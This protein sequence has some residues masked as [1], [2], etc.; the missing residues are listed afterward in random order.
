[1]FVFLLCFALFLVAF[2]IQYLLLLS[3]MH[4]RIIIHRGTGGSK[5][6]Q[7]MDYFVSFFVFVIFLITHLS[8]VLV[9][10]NQSA[11][12]SCLKRREGCVGLKCEAQAQLARLLVG[13][14]RVS[15]TGFRGGGRRGGDFVLL[16]ELLV[17]PGLFGKRHGCADV[18]IG[19]GARAPGG[20]GLEFL[21]DA[22]PSTGCGT[23]LLGAKG[24][25]F[26]QF[27]GSWRWGW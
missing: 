25:L 4:R 17:L 18:P 15:G 9:F 3:C 19:D 16:F 27:H 14:L 1:V 24:G 23:V 6:G 7:L 21:D 26:H 12:A 20:V 5:N 11:S 13:G 2:C 8:D 10:V 22:D